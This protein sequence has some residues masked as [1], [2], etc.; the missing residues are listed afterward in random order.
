[1]LER[2]DAGADPVDEMKAER[3]KKREEKGKERE[4]EGGKTRIRKGQEQGV[5]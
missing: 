5:R 2:M 4:K 3:E 1:M